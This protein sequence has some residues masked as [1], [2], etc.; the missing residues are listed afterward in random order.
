M[1]RFGVGG[2]LSFESRAALD[3]RTAGS[4]AFRRC[5]MVRITP[6]MELLQFSLICKTGTDNGSGL[7]VTLGC[8]HR[9]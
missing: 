7:L 1:R 5:R 9:F 4:G 8:L 6:K 2:F 3:F